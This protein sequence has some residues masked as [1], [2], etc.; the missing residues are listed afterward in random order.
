MSTSKIVTGGIVTVLVCAV[1][2]GLG[3]LAHS[4]VTTIIESKNIDENFIHH[5]REISG[6]HVTVLESK[7]T[8]LCYLEFRKSMSLVD[9]RD[10]IVI[11][12]E[13]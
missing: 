8:N 2:Y 1:L 3:S 9:C 11:L 5:P 7:Q 4:R 13:K 10:F 12:G 6:F